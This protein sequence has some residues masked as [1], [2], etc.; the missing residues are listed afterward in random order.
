MISRSRTS[1]LLVTASLA[2]M[3]AACT[4]GEREVEAAPAPGDAARGQR[5]MAHYQCGSCHTV[6]G[7][8]NARGQGANSLA[9]FGR[10]S[11]IAG[12]VA[13]RPDR[14]AAWIESPQALVPGTTMPDLGVSPED[15]RDMAAYLIGLE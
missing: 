5:L 7:V 12:R 15:A 14:L 2:A 4:P 1:N 6:P 9:A 8:A 10:R 13:N 3:T 11:Y